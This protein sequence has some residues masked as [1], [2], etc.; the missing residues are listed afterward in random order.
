[1]SFRTFL[2]VHLAVQCL[3]CWQTLYVL[4]KNS[5]LIKCTNHFFLLHTAQTSTA[6]STVNPLDYTFNSTLDSKLV[7]YW[8]ISA[9]NDTI[10]FGIIFQGTGWVSNL[11]VL[12][13]RLQRILM[14][15]I[16]LGL[17]RQ[18]VVE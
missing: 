5:Q 16:R 15:Y 13:K 7:I 4:G 18:V 17:A 11:S 8:N 1:M 12:S 14:I 10:D 9:E 6:T 3:F 2:Y